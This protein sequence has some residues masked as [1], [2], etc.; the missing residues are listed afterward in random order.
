MKTCSFIY[1][2]Y[3]RHYI[4]N[5]KKKQFEKEK[6]GFGIMD[7][8]LFLLNRNSDKVTTLDLKLRIFFCN[9]I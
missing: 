8:V 4:L 1:E 7:E 3:D 9:L 5:K 6:K 2:L